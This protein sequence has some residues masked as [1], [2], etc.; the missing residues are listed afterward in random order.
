MY[1]VYTIQS[2][3]YKKVYV[4]YTNDLQRRL[5]LHNSGKVFSTKPYKPYKLIYYEAYQ[6]KEDAQEREIF[7]KSGWGKNYLKRVLKHYFV[8]EKS[9]RISPKI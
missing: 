3:I 2:K 8:V 4:G 6:N 7:L 9:K 1:Y 5:M